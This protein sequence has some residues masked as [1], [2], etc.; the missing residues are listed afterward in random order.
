VLIAFILYH[1][2]MGGGTP[3][4]SPGEEKESDGKEKKVEEKITKREGE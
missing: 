3:M 4:I 1:V 2:G